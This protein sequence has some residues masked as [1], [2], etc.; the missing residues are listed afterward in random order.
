MH[1][2]RSGVRIQ[3]LFANEIDFPFATP[4]LTNFQFALPIPVARDILENMLAGAT[5]RIGTAAKPS[6]KT[7]T[8]S[9]TSTRALRATGETASQREKVSNPPP[10]RNGRWFFSF[11][12]LPND[13]GG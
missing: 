10:K 12:P 6:I 4:F 3:K 1:I 13:C 5:K 7:T 9:I 11:S 2:R 8:T